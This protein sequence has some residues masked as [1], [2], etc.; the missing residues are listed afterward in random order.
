[1]PDTDSEAEVVTPA[2]V[3]PSADSSSQYGGTPRP[4]TEVVVQPDFPKSALGEFIEIGGHAGI[5]IEIVNQSLKVRFKEG[6]VQSFNGNVLRK[7]YAPAKRP[8]PTASP[9]PESG[10]SK[11]SEASSGGRA[12]TKRA[13]DKGEDED[14]ANVDRPTPGALVAEP[15]FEAPLKPIAELVVLAD[16]PKCLL[17]AHVEIGGYTGVVIEL[18]D[19]SLKV[20]SRDGA[21]QRFNARVLQRVYGPQPKAVERSS[22]PTYKEPAPP[23]KTVAPRNIIMNPD[24]NTPVLQIVD[25]IARTDFPQCTLGQ[26]IEITGF[27][28]VVVEVVK[29]SL[30]VKSHD[31]LTRSYNSQVLRKLYA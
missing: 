17:G 4:I 28:G 6:T 16:Y 1:M 24:Y 21:T 2:A 5:V 23:A 26:H 20:K 11:V 8:A 22:R 7:L 31:G 13:A 30:K 9:S 18:L 25:Y 3:T 27:T 19:Q 15:D 14:E 12:V 29:G 10:S